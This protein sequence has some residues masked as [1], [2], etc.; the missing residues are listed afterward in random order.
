[1]YPPFAG[2]FLFFVRFNHIVGVRRFEFQMAVEIFLDVK[3]IFL[4]AVPCQLVVGVLGQIVLVGEERP[5]AAQLQDALAA[6]HDGQLIPAH[7]FMSGFLVRC[8]VAGA[9]AAGIRRVVVE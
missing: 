9:V 8:A 1:M 5:D 2:E 3:H 7:K 4:V 6:V